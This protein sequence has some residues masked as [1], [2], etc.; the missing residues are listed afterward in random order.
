MHQFKLIALYP[1]INDII[2][3]KP[4][5]RML[6]SYSIAQSLA[7]AWNKVKDTLDFDSA[8]EVYGAVA[9]GGAAQYNLTLAT[10]MPY[11]LHSQWRVHNV[12]PDANDPSL[13]RTLFVGSETMAKYFDR[14]MVIDEYTRRPNFCNPL[15]FTDIYGWNVT[16]GQIRND[17][18]LTAQ[19]LQRA[20]QREYEDA[21]ID[22]DHALQFAPKAIKAIEHYTADHGFTDDTTVGELRHAMWEIGRKTLKETNQ[23][24]TLEQVQY[25]HYVEKMVRRGMGEK[26]IAHR[27]LDELEFAYY[28]TGLG[29]HPDDADPVIV[30]ALMKFTGLTKEQYDTKTVDDMRKMIWQLIE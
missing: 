4:L 2:D 5:I 18:L 3:G 21:K 19:C 8:Y 11:D 6:T 23:G 14:T 17:T 7:D 13:L 22:L 30:Q 20:D 26:S 29:Y 9:T 28:R 12:S 25:R 1:E 15:D 27:L 10:V 16:L 24:E